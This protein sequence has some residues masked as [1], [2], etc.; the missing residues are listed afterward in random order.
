MKMGRSRYGPGPIL[1]I[2]AIPLILLFALGDAI[3]TKI[4]KYRKK[5]P[6]NDTT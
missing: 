6:K 2:V 3:Q 1:I 5:Q 4:K